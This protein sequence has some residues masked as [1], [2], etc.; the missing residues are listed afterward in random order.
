VP[1][2]GEAPPEAGGVEVVPPMLTPPVDVTSPPLL[3]P[4]PDGELFKLQ[5]RRGNVV[6]AKAPRKSRVRQVFI[7][8]K[9]QRNEPSWLWKLRV[10]T[11]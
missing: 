10:A 5:A 1:A 9:L 6:R 11:F 2:L 3:P 4:E 8:M 7:I